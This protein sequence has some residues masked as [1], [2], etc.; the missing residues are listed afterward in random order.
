MAGSRRGVLEGFGGSAFTGK[1]AFYREKFQGWRILLIMAT[2]ANP[3]KQPASQKKAP[4]RPKSRDAEE[5]VKSG[6]K[7]LAEIIRKADK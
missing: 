3:K 6:Q 1:E 4:R 7:T 2:K 5:G